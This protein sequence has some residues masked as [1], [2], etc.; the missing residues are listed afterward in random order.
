[1]SGGA[2][3]SFLTPEQGVGREEMRT[4]EDV[5]EMRQAPPAGAGDASDR[6]PAGLLPDD[7]SRM[8]CNG[9]GGTEADPEASAAIERSRA[10]RSRFVTHSSNHLR[11]TSAPWFARNWGLTRCR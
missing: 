8:C 6:G 7:S 4:P 10:P 3:T 9:G 1:M 2:C 5:L 11:G